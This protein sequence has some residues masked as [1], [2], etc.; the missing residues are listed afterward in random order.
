MYS[1]YNIKIAVRACTIVCKKIIAGVVYI[2]I[3]YK[4]GMGLTTIIT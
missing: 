2:K 1:F 3:K 4:E